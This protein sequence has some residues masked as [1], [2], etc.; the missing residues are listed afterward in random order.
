MK[1]LEVRSA[2]FRHLE[3]GVEEWMS[4]LGYS[5]SMTK[6]TPI[7]LHEFFNYLEGKGCN[8]V[9][10]I[11]TRHYLEYYKYIST[12]ENQLYGGGLS[13]SSL[14]H[15]VQALHKFH[16][17]LVHK[18]MGSPAGVSLRYLPR[19]TPEATVLTQSEIKSLFR[20]TQR[21]TLTPLQEAL[22]V[23]DRAML[24]LYYS[25]GLRRQEGTLLNIEDINFNRRSIHIKHG[26]G[27]KERFVP[28]GKETSIQLQ[29]WVYDYRPILTKN[30]KQG[31]LLVSQ[32]GNKISY[33]SL[34]HSL[35]KL[36]TATE[37][38]TLKQK[39]PGLHTFRHSVAT[40]LLQN[41]MD[42][43]NIQRFLGHSSLTS[44]QIYTHLVKYEDF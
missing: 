2:G 19:D 37:S 25:C 7:I 28:F 1:G 39:K 6:R 16:Q 31:K 18:G 27:Y 21:K 32:K 4:I 36:I 12:R 17:Y 13:N 34:Y 10:N 23:R 20:A 11:T 24:H 44:T 41:G 3:K 14:N 5:I 40:H 33:G 30:P 38:E 8:N 22:C 29:E 9:Q 42:M 26:K 43:Q 15:H 35:R